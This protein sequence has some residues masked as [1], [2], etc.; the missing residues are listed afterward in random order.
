M[1]ADLPVVLRLLQAALDHHG[2]EQVHQRDGHEHDEGDEV[3]HL[4]GAET[5]PGEKDATTDSSSVEQTGHK[6]KLN[7]SY[8]SSKHSKC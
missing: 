7:R 6:K 5:V 3:D 2:S 8:K 1:T 4:D